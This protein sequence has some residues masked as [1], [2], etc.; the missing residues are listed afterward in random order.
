M[1][2]L[3]FTDEQLLSLI[4]NT[5]TTKTNFDIDDFSGGSVQSLISNGICKYKVSLFFGYKNRNSINYT[6]DVKEDL[7]YIWNKALMV[8]IKTTTAMNNGM[9]YSEL[10]SLMNLSS[11]ISNIVSSSSIS[12]GSKK[13]VRQ[14]YDD[15]PEF[16]EFWSAYP[17]KDDKKKSFQAWIKH[18]PPIDEVLKT[19]EWQKETEQW[20]KNNGQF[21]PLGETYING[22]RWEAE[23]T[24][25]GV[26]F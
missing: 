22:A 16:L 25:T 9:D 21:I 8:K 23:Q 5:I 12:N 15:Y 4:N 10:N 6:F 18:N 13:V 11:S 3:S 2:N 19:L 17:R 26:P 24:D 7:V 14:S 20:T 1:E